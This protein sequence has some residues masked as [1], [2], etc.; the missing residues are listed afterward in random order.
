MAHYVKWSIEVTY[1][2]NSYGQKTTKTKVFEGKDQTII[3]KD[4]E[5]WRYDN[6]YIIRSDLSLSNFTSSPGVE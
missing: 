5:Q 6:G 4:I 2:D 3:L 1:E